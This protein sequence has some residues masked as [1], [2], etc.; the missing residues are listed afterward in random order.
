[1]EAKYV[2][3][4]D[5]VKE[6]VW[7]RNFLLHLGILSQIPKAITVYCDNAGAIANAKEPRTHMATKH[8]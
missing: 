1:M 4:S 3:A 7:F 5:A 2:A 8:I 6:V